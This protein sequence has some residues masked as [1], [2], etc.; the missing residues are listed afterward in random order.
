MGQKILSNEDNVL[1]FGSNCSQQ[2]PAAKRYIAMLT[3]EMEQIERSS[4]NINNTIIKFKF[5][6]FPNDMK[7]LAFLAGKLPNSAKYFFFHFCRCFH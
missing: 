6:E 5:S 4:F 2:N 1:I 3:K 7:M